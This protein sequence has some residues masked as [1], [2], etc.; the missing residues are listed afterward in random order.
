MEL[1]E[2]DVGQDSTGA[3]GARQTVAGG[4]GRVRRLWPQG[5][6]AARRQDDARGLDQDEPQR[7]VVDQHTVNARA[8]IDDELQGERGLVELDLRSPAH[9]AQQ[10]GDDGTAGGIAVDMDDPMTPVPGLAGQRQ[11]A[12]TGLVEANPGRAQMPDEPRCGRRAPG[13]AR[14][15][16]RQDRRDRCRL[17]E[18]RS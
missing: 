13:R 11:S 14:P 16:H 3:R 7:I 8:R 18:G 17:P 2:L 12:V 1:H 10:C 6:D 4:L 5:T 9:V 15:V